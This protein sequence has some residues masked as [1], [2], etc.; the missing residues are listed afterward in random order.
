MYHERYLAIGC[1]NKHS[2]VS[3]FNRCCHPLAV[4]YLIPSYLC[5]SHRQLNRADLSLILLAEYLPLPG[6][7]TVTRVMFL[8]ACT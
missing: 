5:R 1:E 2:D 6:S 7:L 4:G 8:V 3:F